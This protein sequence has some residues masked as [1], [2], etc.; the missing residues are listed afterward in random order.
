MIKY[1]TFCD[2]L[3][4]IFFHVLYLHVGALRLSK[5]KSTWIP[6]KLCKGEEVSCFQTI[7]NTSIFFTFL[8]HTLNLAWNLI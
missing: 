2:S 6:Q 7:L 4:S 5:Y 8:R 3:D 1:L